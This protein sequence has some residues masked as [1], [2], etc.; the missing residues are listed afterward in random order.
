MCLV[1]LS[2]CFPQVAPPRPWRRSCR[3]PSSSGHVRYST[4]MD[5][6]SETNEY[7]EQYAQ[8]NEPLSSTYARSTSVYTLKQSSMA[9]LDTYVLPASSLPPPPLPV[10]L[11]PSL[12]FASIAPVC[13]FVSQCT[14]RTRPRPP[15][16]A[17]TWATD[18]TA[19]TWELQLQPRPWG[20]DCTARLDGGRAR[21]M[22][23]RTVSQRKRERGLGPVQLGF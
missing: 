14:T 15:M 2:I 4:H 12:T 13:H 21:R 10:N 3:A 17:P 16:S 22:G 11:L 19:S 1:C 6:H 8:S 20:V 9:V 7:R 5:V 18:V 23:R